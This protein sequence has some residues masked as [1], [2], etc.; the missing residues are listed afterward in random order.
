MAIVPTVEPDHRGATR[1]RGGVNGEVGTLTPS[2]RSR[3]SRPHPLSIV[4]LVV[5]LALV[6]VLTWASWSQYNNTENRLLDLRVREA[7]SLLTVALPTIQTPLASAAELAQA[8]N[9]DPQQFKNLVSPYVGPGK[10]FVSVSLWPLQPGNLA[11]SMTVGTVPGL[12]ASPAE[13]QGLFGR[14]GRSQVLAVMGLLDQPQPRLGYGFVP[15]GGSPRFAVYAESAIPTNRRLRLETSS[16]F[17]DLNYAVYLGSSERSADLL[18]TSLAH[19]PVTGRRAATTV[20]FGDA[21]FRLVMTPRGTLGGSLSKTLPWVIAGVG[22]VLA[23][24]AALVTERLVRRRRRAEDDAAGFAEDAGESR[25][26]YAEQRGLAQALQHALLPREVPDFA[27]LD[28]GVLYLPGV[29]GVEIGGDWYDIVRLGDST[30]LLVLGDV[31]GRGLRAATI[32]A[33]LRYAIRAYAAQGDAPELILAKLSHVLSL[34]RD[35]H[36]ATILCAAVDVDTHEMTVANAGHLNPLLLADGDSRFLATDVGIPVG[37]KDDSAY[38]PVTVHVP[39]SAT[40]VA[41]TD[42]LVERRRES[43]EVSLD[44]MRQAAEGGNGSLDQMLR[45]LV[46]DL[47]PDGSD[48]DIAVVGVRWQN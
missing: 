47:T 8:T 21:T 23:V 31:S 26:L 14:A 25:R 48:D 16:A 32:M 13:A 36:F 35:G 42:G 33:S 9:G 2:G 12:A 46:N 19:L 1:P 34:D 29:G 45:K 11:P 30:F 6:G 41:F 44:R 4:V 39:P 5:S 27:G 10:P 38:V 18:A 15:P 24:T 7:G 43:L 22:T 20:P 17:S 40:L 28:I 3:S 37:V